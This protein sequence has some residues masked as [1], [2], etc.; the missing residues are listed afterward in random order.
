MLEPPDDGLVTPETPG[1]WLKSGERWRGCP[2]RCSV[3]AARRRAVVGGGGRSSVPVGA[4]R[5]RVERRYSTR[6][7]GEPRPST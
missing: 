6:E 4:E 5:L 2:A 1:L 3:G 7:D